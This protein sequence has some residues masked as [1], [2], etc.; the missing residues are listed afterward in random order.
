MNEV[1]LLLIYLATVG[2]TGAFCWRV[3]HQTGYD[4]GFRQGHADGYKDGEWWGVVKSYES[5]K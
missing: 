2:V 5:R 1:V 4:K 3:G